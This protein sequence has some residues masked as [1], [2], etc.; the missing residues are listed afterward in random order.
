MGSYVH[1]NPVH[2]ENV[3]DDGTLTANIAAIG[4]AHFIANPDERL[5]AFAGLA[6]FSGGYYAENDGGMTLKDAMAACCMDYE[7]RIQEKIQTTL[8]TDEGVTTIEY[9]HRGTYAIWPDGRTAG[10]GMVG[11]KYQIVQPQA[12]GDLGQAVMDTSGANVVAAGI[13]GQPQGAKSYLA[14]KLPEGLTIGGE[15]RHD[16]YLTILN[17]YDGSSG[18]TGLF[19]PIRLECTNMTTVTFKSGVTNRFKFRHTGNVDDKVTEAREALGVA[20]EWSQAWR[21]AAEQLLA[22]PLAGDELKQFVEKLLPTPKTVTTDVGARGWSDKR[23]KIREI[24]TKADT[25]EFGRGT[26]YAVLQ[27]VQEWADWF[28]ATKQPGVKGELTRF[29]RTLDGA[30]TE[31]VK[32]RAATLLGI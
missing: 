30:Q 3:D 28:S 15:D 9:P 5:P 12:A 25:C 18:L 11:S 27:G 19:A 8:I 32:L 17:S 21:A 23:F 4:R 2:D 6:K 16:L 13:Y 22:T 20:E 7:V 31:A 24:I 14:F 26:A 10:M 1:N 29:T